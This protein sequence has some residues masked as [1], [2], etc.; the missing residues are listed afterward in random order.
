MKINK[1][2]IAA[3]VGVL[4]FIGVAISQVISV[5]QVS[6][7]NPTDL[8]QIIPLGQPSAANVFAKPAQI[9]SQSGYQKY[10]Q[11][12]GTY[13]FGNSDSYIVLHPST[14]IS[15][16]TIVLAAA[17]SDGARECFFSAG[18]GITTL[19]VS[20]NTGQSINNAI[21]TLAANAGACYLYSLGNLTWDRN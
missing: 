7:V 21:T 1:T 19:V 11:G 8:L 3:G 6:I 12:T 18:A 14:T 5:P 4:A 10:A 20:A 17:P 13:T 9:T 15:S 2:M 16:L